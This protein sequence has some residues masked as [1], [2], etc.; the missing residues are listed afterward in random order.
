LAFLGAWPVLSASVALLYGGREPVLTE[1]PLGESVPLQFCGK[2]YFDFRLK[3]STNSS[4]KGKYTRVSAASVQQ[5]STQADILLL[6]K[7]SKKVLERELLI[8][9]P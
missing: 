7:G 6:M 8:P 2:L 4:A 1:T 3:V 9:L 5:S